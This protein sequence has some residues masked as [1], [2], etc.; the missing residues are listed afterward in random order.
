MI[1]KLLDVFLKEY[2]IL[3]NC[4]I[5]Q[6]R[7]VSFE[8]LSCIIAF[9]VSPYFA[10]DNCWMSKYILETDSYSNDNEDGGVDGYHIIANENEIIVKLNQSK[11]SNSLQNNEIEKYF[12]SVNKYIV[13]TSL[14][15]SNGY[16]SLE[17]IRTKIKLAEEKYPV[18]SISYELHICTLDISV[19]RKK[20][21]E[22]IFDAEFLKKNEFKLI[23]NDKNSIENDIEYITKDI[24]DEK[25]NNTRVKLRSKIKSEAIE[26]RNSK[27]LVTVIDGNQ[28]FELINK[29][30]ETNIELSR[31]FAGNVRGFL[32]ESEVNLQMKKTIEDSSITFLSKNNGIVVVCDKLELNPNHIDLILENPIIVNGQQTVSSIY[33]YA[34]NPSQKNKVQVQIKFIELNNYSSD[35]KQ[36]IILDIAKASNDSNQVTDLDLLSNR[37]LFKYIKKSFRKLQYQV[38]HFLK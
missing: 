9:K 1:E 21:I 20:E 34:K 38:V 8:L 13:N 25:F 14:E 15:L 12:R 11:Y 4:N 2:K 16:T 17:K 3:P 22:T 7:Q 28:V 30:F 18:S 26:Y 31:L 29:E 36:E 23:I 37:K 24:I 5:E 19:D 35:V 6:R 27:V 33:L 10:K 32:E